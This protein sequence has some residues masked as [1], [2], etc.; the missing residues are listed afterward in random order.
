[1]PS[2][3]RQL[4]PLH[5]PRLPVRVAD[6]PEGQGAPGQPHL[7]R[8]RGVPLHLQL[9]RPEHPGRVRG[10]SLER[11]RERCRAHQGGVQGECN[12]T[13]TV[14]DRRNIANS[15]FTTD[16]RSEFLIPLVAI[17]REHQIPNIAEKLSL[18]VQQE[19]Q[20]CC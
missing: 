20:I 14:G 16:N 9:A 5:S 11:F 1:M 13:V 3:R 18:F 7:R 19:F 12:F 2:P 8:D 15:Q 10:Y 6:Q 4:H 17:V